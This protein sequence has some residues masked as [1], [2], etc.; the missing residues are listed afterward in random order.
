MTPPETKFAETDLLKIGYE[1]RGTGTPLL[2]LHGWPDDVRTWDKVADGLVQ[3]GHSTLAPWLRGC[4][5]TTFR[6]AGTPRSGQ[7]TAFAQD[8][9]DLLD[10]LGIDQVTVVGHDW[11]ARAGYVLAALWPERVERLVVL[12]A[13]YETGIKPGWEID[14]AQAH[15]YWYQWFWHTERGREALERNRREVCRYLWQTWAPHMAFTDT[16][17]EATAS[18]WENPDWVASTLYAYRVRWGAAPKDHRYD[19]L[20]A[21][22]EAHPPI[23]VPTTVLHGEED[24]ASLVASSAGQESSFTAGY[25]RETLPGVGHFVQRECP[26]AV[27]QAVL[28]ETL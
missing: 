23:A 28:G 25:R 27:L 1:Q 17:F 8:A 9:I 24:G 11:G 26:E 16:E 3:A 2:L 19:A 21:R 7:T 15:A 18:A 5:P 6:D 4:G 10:V 22:L 20:E 12:A 13:G 14:P